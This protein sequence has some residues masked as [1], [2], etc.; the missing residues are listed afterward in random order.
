[1]LNPLI[2]LKN[3]E[4]IFSR[5]NGGLFKFI[6][7]KTIS[8]FCFRKYG[9]NRYIFYFSDSHPISIIPSWPN[10]VISRAIQFSL[11][12]RKIKMKNITGICRYNDIFM[13]ISRGYNMNNVQVKII[14]K[15]LLLITYRIIY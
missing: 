10:D 13:N 1:M 15:N 4:L 8:I 9:I 14:N 6:K 2:R 11:H 3:L 5:K 12:D 7:N